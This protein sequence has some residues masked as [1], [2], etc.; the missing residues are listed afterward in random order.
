M[1]LGPQWPAPITPILSAFIREGISYGESGVDWI[2]FGRPGQ[3][4]SQPLT[5]TRGENMSEKRVKL[6]DLDW[7]YRGHR[8]SFLEAI[9]K[10]LDRS[11]FI[12]G[13]ELTEF[14][15]SFAAWLGEE[16]QC[17]GC[18]NGTDAISLAA[19]ALDLP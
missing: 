8:A 3:S 7:I 19:S 1:R 6:M 11:A 18:A 12:G 2:A 15:R 4:L 10:V 17:V 9:T 5:C 16:A 14:E 13:A